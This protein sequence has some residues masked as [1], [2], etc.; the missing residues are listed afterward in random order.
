MQPVSNSQVLWRKIHLAAPAMHAASDRFWNQPGLA[1]IYP[2]FLIQLHHVMMGG[3]RLMSFAAQQAACL[4]GDAAATMAAAYLQHH[5]EEEKD[6]ADWLLDDLRVLGISAQTVAQTPPLPGVVS[7]IGEQ[8][9]WITSF[10]PVVVFG[11]LFVLEGSP[12]LVHQLEQIQAQTGLPAEAFRCLRTHAEDDPEHI[13]DLNR[14]LDRMPLTSEQERRIALSAFS[15][16]E[17]VA[18]LLD[19]LLARAASPPSDSLTAAEPALVP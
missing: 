4:S 14:T 9:F 18:A 11:Y 15:T 16:I 19:E 6:H 13:E 3:L 17:A 8:F 5:I 2:Q 10:H 7:L 1:R 12:P